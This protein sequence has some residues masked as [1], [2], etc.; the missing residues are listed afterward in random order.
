MIQRFIT[1]YNVLLYCDIIMPG[2][3]GGGTCH[4]RLQLPDFSGSGNAKAF[5]RNFE[6]L[7]L[8]IMSLFIYRMENHPHLRVTYQTSFI[9][10]YNF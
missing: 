2:G 9:S 1:K 8:I 4:S 3:E 10:E 7:A 5:F 6:L